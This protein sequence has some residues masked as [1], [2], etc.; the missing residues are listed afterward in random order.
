MDAAHLCKVCQTL[1]LEFFLSEERADQRVP[2]G[3]DDD[4]DSFT[5]ITAVPHHSSI[6]ELHVSARSGCNLCYMILSR[7]HD[8]PDF[9]QP[10][11][12]VDSRIQLG[13]MF[14]QYHRLVIHYRGASLMM[15]IYSIALNTDDGMKKPPR[16]NPVI[17]WPGDSACVV[18]LH[19]IVRSLSFYPLF[20]PRA[21]TNVR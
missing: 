20:S 14:Q 9:K 16:L 12:E 5:M 18:Q 11:H 3:P 10:G 21:P 17:Y 6:L 19:K 4:K 2:P 8:L 13:M 15:P 7:I 1:D